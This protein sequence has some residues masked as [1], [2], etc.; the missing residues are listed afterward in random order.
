LFAI[1]NYSSFNLNRLSIRFE[2][3]LQSIKSFVA[4]REPTSTSSQ[5]K[6]TLLDSKIQMNKALCEFLLNDAKSMDEFKQELN[7]ICTLQKL[8]FNKLKTLED[9]QNC[10]LFFNY[11]L[12]LYFNRQYS[13]CFKIIDKLYYQFS[14]LVD[15]QLARKIHFLFVDLLIQMKQVT[16]LL[17]LSSN[18]KLLICFPTSQ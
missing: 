4:N 13:Q 8:N 6:S 5:Q 18:F 7:K 3:C 15:E 16:H 1:F 11:A 12:T 2:A 10:N 17:P 14:E 9:A